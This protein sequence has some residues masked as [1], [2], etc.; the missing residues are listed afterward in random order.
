MFVLPSHFEPWGVVVHEFASAGF[1][2]ICSDKVGAKVDFVQ[3]NYNGYVYPSGNIS[4][5]KNTLRNVMNKSNDELN[6][7]GERS[8]VLAKKI[9]PIVWSKKLLEVLNK[10]K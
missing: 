5:L 2:I 4:E 7:M 3:D 6:L 9:T 8:T 1:P 10:S